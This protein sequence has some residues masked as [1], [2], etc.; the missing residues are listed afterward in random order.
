MYGQSKATRSNFAVPDPHH[1]A[2]RLPRRQVQVARPMQEGDPRRG[3][4][5][6]RRDR[7]TP[8][9]AAVAEAT[10]LCA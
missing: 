9:D 8:D 6:A 2:V 10:K 1:R 4:A 3:I 7:F 5:N